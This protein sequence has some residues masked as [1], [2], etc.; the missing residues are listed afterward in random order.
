LNR[1]QWVSRDELNAMQHTKLLHLLEYAYHYVPYYRRTFDEVGFRPI[2]LQH[3]LTNINK[4]PI[5]TKEI[6]RKNIAELLTTEPERRRR[7]TI[8]STSGST[9]QPLIFMQDS[10][11]RDTVTA[12]IQHYM[13]RVGWKLGDFHVWICGAPNRPSLRKKLRIQ[14]IDRVWNRFQ[15]DAFS[16]DE[17]AMTAFAKRL[18]RQKVKILYGY[19]SSLYHFSRFIRTSPYEGI[20]F[21]AIFSSA[22]ILIPSERQFIEE[23]F[24]CRIFD[25]YGTLELGWIACE[26]QAHTGYHINAENSYIE[27]LNDGLPAR[28]EEVGNIVVTNLNNLGMP[29]IRY[30]IGDAGALSSDDNCLCGRASSMLKTIEGR[31]CDSFKTSD[32][33]T[34]YTHFSSGFSCLAHPTITQFQIVQKSLNNIIVRLVP[35]GV[36]PQT[37]LAEIS[38]V[39]RDVFGENVTVEFE[40]PNEITP[41]PSGKRKYAISELNRS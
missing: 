37:T 35:D 13:G 40:F 17:E 9:G 20:N 22:E 36:I 34:I 10:D 11:F 7:L 26:C 14:M 16:I 21:D 6:V 25:L 41:L 15:L 28:P 19:A 4:I 12:E 33:R 32:G 2:D 27:I 23:T 38:Q 31:I 29:F 1:T 30:S 18:H 5:L 8:R 3:D 39:F 24:Q